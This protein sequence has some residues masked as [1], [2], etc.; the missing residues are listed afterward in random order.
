MV[1]ARNDRDGPTVLLRS[2]SPI[3]KSVIESDMIYLGRRLVIPR[4]PCFGAVLGHNRALIAAK[5]HPIRIVRV[6]PQLMIIVAARRAFYR[7]ESSAAVGRFICRSV[8]DINDIWIFGV[9]DSLRKIPAASPNAL[10]V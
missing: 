10:L 9:D 1:A 4:T 8:T 2:R 6:D 7:G 3:W 5:N